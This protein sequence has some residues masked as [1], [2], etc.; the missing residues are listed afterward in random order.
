[1]ILPPAYHTEED[2]SRLDGD[3]G[4]RLDGDDGGR[5]GYPI[6]LEFFGRMVATTAVGDSW[7]CVAP[8]RLRIV[9][10]KRAEPRK[11][12]PSIART[13]KQAERSG[14]KVTSITTPDGATLR[15][16]EPEPTEATNPWLAK[17]EKATTK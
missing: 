3:D 13:I 6:P 12:K 17:L 16:N 5:G 1:V 4:G 9:S 8:G 7:V 2:E 14:K 11:R 15:F 10:T